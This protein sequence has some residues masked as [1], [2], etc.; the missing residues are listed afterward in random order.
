MCFLA[1][2]LAPVHY[3]YSVRRFLHLLDMGRHDLTM[4]TVSMKKD[5]LNE[6]VPVLV[7]RN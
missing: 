4:L 3:C 7:A 2:G 5:V 1:S 6:I